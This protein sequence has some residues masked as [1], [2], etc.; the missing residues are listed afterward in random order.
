LRLIARTARQ[1]TKP[2][3]RG[4]AAAGRDLAAA[5]LLIGLGIG[6]LSVPPPV[7][8][9]LK[10]VIRGLALQ[11]CRAAAQEALSL[12]SAAAVRAFA[13]TRFAREDQP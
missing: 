7:I 6:E 10:A 13:K 1:R 11:E 4:G 2:E 12:T 8:P 9:R 5:P 3:N